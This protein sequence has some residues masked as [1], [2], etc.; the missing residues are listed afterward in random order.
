MSHTTH[1]ST[2]SGAVLLEAVVALAIVGTVGLAVAAM[3]S[4]RAAAVS[5]A[6]EREREVREASRL[7]TAVSL[8]PRE[9]L[10]RHMG[11]SRQGWMNLV[12]ERTA[13]DLFSIAIQ[14]GTSAQ[15]LLRTALFRPAVR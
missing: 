3:A 8:W 13:P 10:D 9:D 1:R 5:R 6:Q 14:D 15:P 2:R 12:I 7:L 4:D 11:A